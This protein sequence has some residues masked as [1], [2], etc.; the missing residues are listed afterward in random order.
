MKDEI[1]VNLRDI[2]DGLFI[3]V[4]IEPKDF[5]YRFAKKEPKP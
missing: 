1:V 3:N 2:S 5:E 4:P